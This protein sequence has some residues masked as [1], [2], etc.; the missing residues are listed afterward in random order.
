MCLH[1]KI[2]ERTLNFNRFLL[3]SEPL[4]NKTVKGVL[5]SSIERLSGQLV[6]FFVIVIM[7]R[8]LTQADYGLV[9]MLM[10]F[11]GIAQN[12]MDCGVSQALIRKQ[13]RDQKDCSTAFFFNIVL[14]GVLYVILFFCAPLISK[15]YNQ[16]ELTVLTRV[17]SF[18][19]II[20]AFMMVQKSLFTVKLDFKRQAKASL[21]AAIISGGCGIAMAYTG[22]GVWAIVYYQLINLIFNALLLWVLSKWRPSF[23]FS[24]DSFKYFFKFGS[25]LTVA[26]VM[27]TIYNDIYLAAIG[28]VYQ[29]SALGLYTRAHQF[30]TLPSYN[31]ASIIQRV[32][33]PVLC[34]MQDD[35]DKLRETFVKFMRMTSFAV[36]PMMIGLSVVSKPLIIIFLGE[37]W[38]YSSVLLSIL[39]LALM[40]LPM[41]SLNLNLLQVRGRTDYYLK[42]EIWKKIV[43]LSFLFGTLPFG[44]VIMCWGQVLRYILDLVVDTYYTGKYLDIGFFVQLKAV[45]PSLIISAIMAIAVWFV[46]LPFDSMW[47]KLP[48]GFVTGVVSYV[49]LSF[50]GSRNEI[51]AIKNLLIKRKPYLA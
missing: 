51:N 35:K 32:T 44:L 25:N 27:H 45:M 24:W 34:S 43:G 31:M 15:F 37:S 39:C 21:T 22:W 14:S 1:L 10:I 40:W 18:S 8:V 3:M 36:F 41:D 9:G 48:L 28:K 11:I 4:K 42:C 7:S 47:V 30:G 23:E 12:L 29:A 13:D 5:W 26:G 19:V 33:Y 38:E 50:I 20:N 17:I 16:P 49:A 2:G 46:M 6:G